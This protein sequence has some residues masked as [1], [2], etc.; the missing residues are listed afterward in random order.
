MNTVL[1]PTFVLHSRHYGETSALLV[2]FTQTHGRVSVVARGV[3]GKLKGRCG[4]LQPFVPLQVD[5]VGKGD[6]HTLT[7]VESQ[8]A[9]VFLQ[10]MALYCGLYLNELLMRCLQQ[11]DDSYSDLFLHYAAALWDLT[12][13]DPMIYHRCLRRFE[14]KLL[15]ALGYALPLKALEEVHCTIDPQGFYYYD[16]EGCFYPVDDASSHGL[17]HRPRVFLGACLLALA[18]DDYRDPALLPAMKR[19][20]RFALLPLLGNKPLQVLRCLPTA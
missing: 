14:K 12:Q 5:W 20:L 3:Q 7:T 17:K 4:L 16:H 8:G 18:Q 11:K 6:L 19:L 10:G 2:L 13:S 9:P 1:H 15:H